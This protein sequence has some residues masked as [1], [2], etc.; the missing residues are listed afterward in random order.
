MSNRDYPKSEGGLWPNRK[1]RDTQ[2]DWRGK[3]EVTREQIQELVKMGRAGKIPTLQVG[4][5]KRM[6]RNNQPYIFLSAEAFLPEEQQQPQQQSGWGDQQQP[7]DGWGQPQQQ[8]AP[9]RND[10]WGHPPPQQPP[11]QAAPPNDWDN[12]APQQGGYD[13]GPAP[14][15]DFD[16]DDI[17]F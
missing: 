10:G 16:D 5:W 2:P 8:A 4:A 14:N 1:T 11:Q 17:P 15:N 12:R 6:S 7:Q 9:Q 3:I 13:D